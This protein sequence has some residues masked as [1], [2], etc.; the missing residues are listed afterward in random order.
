MLWNLV[1]DQCHEQDRI[2]LAKSPEHCKA[3]YNDCCDGVIALAP[4]Q[5]IV[6]SW[7]APSSM[8]AETA[9]QTPGE[10][11]SGHKAAGR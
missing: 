4:H 2:H 5:A 7:M 1:S 9:A 3:L 11:H 10:P 6:K 8:L